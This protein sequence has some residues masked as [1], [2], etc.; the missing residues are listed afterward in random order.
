VRTF[1][2]EETLKRYETSPERAEYSPLTSSHLAKT[3]VRTV[4]DGLLK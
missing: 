4:E 1:A 2:D 3:E